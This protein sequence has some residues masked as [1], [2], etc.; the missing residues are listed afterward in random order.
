MFEYDVLDLYGGVGAAAEGYRRAGLSVLS[1]DIAPQPDNPGAFLQS[2]VLDL[3]PE[4]LR[5]FRLVHAS[6]PCQFDAAISK[7]TN[8][9]LRHRYPD[10]YG[11]TRAL[12]EASGR[13]YVIETTSIPRERRHVTL[14]GEMFGLRVQRHRNFELGGWSMVAPAHVPHRGRVIG[15]RHGVVT[16]PVEAGGDGYYFQVYGNGGGKGSVAQWRD[17][18][19]IDWTWNRKSIAEA[20][21]PAYTELIGREFVSQGVV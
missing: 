14:C 6:S 17:A 19:G 3:S 8:R 13:P 4:F 5:R 7:G 11:P 20:I 15:Y 2:D 10:L 12:L 21:P 1:V 16:L 18:M 9:H